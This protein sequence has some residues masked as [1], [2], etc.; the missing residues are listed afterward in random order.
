[1]KDKIIKGTK[2]FNLILKNQKKVNNKGFIY[3]RSLKNFNNEVWNKISLVYMK[4][5]A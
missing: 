4:I 3:V 2:L 1:M 5:K